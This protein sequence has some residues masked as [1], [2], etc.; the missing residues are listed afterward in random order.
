MR[1]TSTDRP[2]LAGYPPGAP[3]TVDTSAYT[4]VIELVERTTAAHAD[5]IAIAATDGS[6]TFAELLTRSRAWTAWLMDAGVHPG[7]RVGVMLPNASAFPITLLGTLGAGAVQV[8]I[9]P[10]YTTRELRHQLLDS[11]ARV[12]VVSHT[13]LPVARAALDGTSVE[14]LV[15]VGGDAPVLETGLHA[16]PFVVAL[17]QGAALPRV[18]AP[19]LSRDHL[20]LLQYTGG[21]TGV[22][23]GAELTH[24]NLIAN[25]LQMRAMLG[26]TVEQGRE[27]IVTA[28]PLYHIFALT[29]NFLTF[30]TFGA[31][32]VLV[33][34]PRDPAQLVAAFTGE[35]ITVVTGVNTLFGNLLALPQLDDIDLRRIKLA[36]GGG[37]AIQGAVSDGW[38]ARSGRHILEGYGLSETAPVVSINSW[39]NPAFTASIGFPV[40]STNLIVADEQGLALPIGS[41]GELCVKGPQVMRGYWNQPEANT[42]A[43]T[44]D[45]YF[46]TGD[47]GTLDAQGFVRLLDRKKDMVL[48][49]GFNVYPNEI[50]E[51]IAR[52]PGV[53]ECA[54]V[55]MPDARSG[56]VVKAFI[57]RPSDGTLTQEEVVAHCRNN[58]A[59]YKVP[60]HVEFIAELPKSTV[61]KIL[62]RALHAAPVPTAA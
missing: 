23:K 60:K 32:N 33:A 7:D 4:N 42:T 11:G 58:L 26:G 53:A 10:M 2:W 27:T 5:R 31:R 30:L 56:E 21:T 50:E 47:I 18:E 16:T 44:P 36:I 48:V 57:V 3:A 15:V 49:S 41:E 25:V 9:N 59:P 6:L 37:S 19:T 54:V 12:L 52:L 22:S 17:E 38:H 1:I 8:G 24:G 51:V 39:A 40:P 13:A 34:N 46:R 62:R 35:A 20:A 14:R 43:F 45:G 61:G 28:L 29:V 55:G